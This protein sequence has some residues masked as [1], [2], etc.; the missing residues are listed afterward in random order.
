M[1][2]FI[3]NF[4][5]GIRKQAELA[6]NNP[7][8]QEK[9]ARRIHITGGNYDR[10]HF[11]QFKQRMP[12]GL[13]EQQYM[14]LFYINMKHNSSN[15]Q[16]NFANYRNLMIEQKFD[17]LL[18]K[19]N[20][21]LL[22]IDGTKKDIVDQ[23][24]LLS[25]TRIDIVN[26]KK[27]IRVLSKDPANI[28]KVR[29][30]KM[31][32]SQLQKLERELMNKIMELKRQRDELMRVLNQT[33]IQRRDLQQNKDIEK[34]KPLLQKLREHREQKQQI[35]VLNKEIDILQSGFKINRDKNGE[36]TWITQGQSLVNKSQQA[37]EQRSSFIEQRLQ[38]AE[39]NGFTV[40]KDNQRDERGYKDRGDLPGNR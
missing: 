39:K 19:E 34:D 12:K 8:Y 22:S 23:K 36:M 9:L 17:K 15:R 7:Q 13:T 4:I 25:R 2:G 1:A 20:K 24:K 26:I 27:R 29:E 28:D 33:Q 40:S 37:N 5:K 21:L 16:L 11:E 6:K 10:T 30:L 31:K 35:K 18:A 14:R 3:E 32:L 38:R